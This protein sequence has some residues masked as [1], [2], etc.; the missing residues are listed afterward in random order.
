M[1]A[2]YQVDTAFVLM[3]RPATGG[4][5]VRAPRLRSEAM[6]P[7]GCEVGRWGSASGRGGSGRSPV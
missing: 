2:E 6:G 1:S 7:R 5:H 3:P 4:A